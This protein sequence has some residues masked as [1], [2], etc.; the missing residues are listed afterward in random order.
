MDRRTCCD[1]KG[2][3]S[4]LNTGKMFHMWGY[5]FFFSHS[6]SALQQTSRAADDTVELAKIKKIKKKIYVSV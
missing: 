6:L 5:F 1:L 2:P 3:H 4:T